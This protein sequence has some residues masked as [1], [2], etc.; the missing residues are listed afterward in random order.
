[1]LADHAISGES[2]DRGSR[3]SV[4]HGR[5][6]RDA[7]AQVESASSV[8]A[9]KTIWTLV[10][11]GIALILLVSFIPGVQPSVSR[12]APKPSNLHK[13]DVQ[14]VA[15]LTRFS[16]GL[17]DKWSVNDNPILSFS[18]PSAADLVSPINPGTVLPVSFTFPSAAS[19]PSQFRSLSSLTCTIYGVLNPW[20]SKQYG[21]LVAGVR[22]DGK[23][24]LASNVVL[25][26]SSGGTAAASV[27]IN[28]PALATGGTYYL[29]AVCDTQGGGTAVGSANGGVGNRVVISGLSGA[30][31]M[32]Y[33]APAESRTLWSNA[34]Q[35]DSND[36]P[37]LNITSPLSGDLISVLQPLQVRWT[38]LTAAVAAGTGLTCT[39][40]FYQDM[41]AESVGG[42][43]TP[44]F[45]AY[46]QVAT[47]ISYDPATN[48][49]GGAEVILSYSVFSE[50]PFYY[51]RVSCAT[52]AG[53]TYSGMA[54][55]MK[56]VSGVVPGPRSGWQQTW[57][58]ANTETSLLSIT[59]PLPGQYLAV[60]TDVQQTVAWQP[61]NG[62]LLPAGSYRCNVTL[63][64][65]LWDDG[66]YLP[67]SRNAKFTSITALHVAI[68][69]NPTSQSGLGTITVLFDAGYYQPG[70]LQYIRV[71][72]ATTVSGP[73]TV[74]GVGGPFKFKLAG[75]PS[76]GVIRSWAGGEGVPDGYKGDATGYT[77]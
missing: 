73:S 19:L 8:I 62:T 53:M 12:S 45:T 40:G 64:S 10:I 14:S 11:G 46:N 47:G 16:L 72:C 68:P 50:L 48:P 17:T 26:L 5:G 42:V 15:Q 22:W 39:V 41:Y 2:G 43:T 23:W 63:L 74:G 36:S 61:V 32:R 13:R 77:A 69:Y 60:G 35:W 34:F 6:S 20:D 75:G 28:L 76:D 44:R 30:F 3:E 67:S 37:S 9:G 52:S 49:Q 21:S 38:A 65:N 27:P 59:N 56:I 57:A 18:R 54:G 70:A 71:S 51:L 29:R 1:M 58:F 24:V 33:I 66:R 7:T 4:A 55:P 25:P 31:G